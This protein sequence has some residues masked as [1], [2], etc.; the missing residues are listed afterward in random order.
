[1]EPVKYF[2]LERVPALPPSQP[3]TGLLPCPSQSAGPKVKK[4]QPFS[5]VAQLTGPSSFLLLQL[6]RGLSEL[7]PG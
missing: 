5:G 6:R 7:W 1:M 2:H 3:S 4:A